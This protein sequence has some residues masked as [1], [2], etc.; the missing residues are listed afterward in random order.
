MMSEQEQRSAFFHCLNCENQRGNTT[1]IIPD[2]RKI[3][4]VKKEEK[5]IIAFRVRLNYFSVNAVKIPCLKHKFS[6]FILLF[7]IKTDR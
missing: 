1:T 6:V 5:C 7:S 4:T 3:K 2:N